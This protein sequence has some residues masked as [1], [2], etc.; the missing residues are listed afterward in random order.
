M[1]NGIFSISNGAGFLPSTVSQQLVTS[2]E[3]NGSASAE[4][5]IESDDS[6]SKFPPGQSTWG[7]GRKLR[8]QGRSLKFFH[9][10]LPMKSTSDLNPCCKAQKIKCSASN[11]EENILED[12]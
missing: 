2:W 7:N 9:A 10:K 6:S 3:W 5:F 8:K 4:I 12:F 1:K 11:I